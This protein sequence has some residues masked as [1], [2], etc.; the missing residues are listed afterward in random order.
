MKGNLEKSKYSETGL[1]FKI[2]VIVYLEIKQESV[3]YGGIVNVFRSFLVY[4][5]ISYVWL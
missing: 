1:K 5:S 2:Q 3:V 4:G